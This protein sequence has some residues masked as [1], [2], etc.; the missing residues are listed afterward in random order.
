L[1]AGRF[2]CCTR[3][4]L[5]IIAVADVADGILAIA[6]RGQ[7]GERYTLANRNLWLVELLQIVAAAGKVKAPRLILPWPLLAL[8]ALGGEAWSRLTGAGDDRLCLETMHMARRR[9]FFNSQAT[10][11]AL[12][13]VPRRSIESTVAETVAWVRAH[14]AAA[15]AAPVRRGNGPLSERGA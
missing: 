7:P 14:L 1:L 9:Q 8:V 4:G 11:S 15:G 12:G 5:N 3:T 2:P 6:E 13:W 10:T